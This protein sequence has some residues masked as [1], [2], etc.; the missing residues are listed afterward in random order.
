MRRLIRTSGI[1]A[2]GFVLALGVASAADR[3]EQ[4]P[5]SRAYF[6]VSFGGERFAP[7]E[8]HYGL[9]LDHDSRYADPSTLPLV[10]FDFTRRGLHDAR[11]NGLSV[12][13]QRYRLRQSEE[14]AAAEA[15]GAPA[16]EAAPAEAAPAEAAPADGGEQAAADG[17]EAA[18]EEGGFFS[19]MW[20]GV[21]GFFGGLFGG[22]EEEAPAETAEAPAEAAPAEGEAPAEAPADGMFSSYGVVDWGLLALGVAGVGLAASEVANGDEDPDF[23]DADGDGLPDGGVACTQDPIP[24]IDPD[25]TPDGCDPNL[26]AGRQGGLTSM[27]M[28]VDHQEWLDGGTGH[29]G[30][31]EGR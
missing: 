30:D 22:D 14:E 18:A 16:E 3:N 5:E 10:Q 7:R 13:T 6:S 1:A 4:A 20:G 11:V 8:L 31:L 2:A 9:R 24:I 12:L 29:M 27:K 21:T 19:N 15:G 17:G 28:D 23:K 25:G 26:F